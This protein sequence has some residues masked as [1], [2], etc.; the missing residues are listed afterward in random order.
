MWYRAIQIFYFILCQ[1]WK[2]ML[3][4]DLDY[5]IFMRKHQGICPLNLSCLIYWHRLVWVTSYLF[6]SYRASPSFISNMYFPLFFLIILGIINSINLSWEQTLTFK[7][8][9]IVSSF[10]FHCSY[11]NYFLL[12]TWKKIYLAF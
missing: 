5:F 10:L 3:C 4:K 1:F 8:F 6:R 12:F 9:S 2:C 7:N 11:L